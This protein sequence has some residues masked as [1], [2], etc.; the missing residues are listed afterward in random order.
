V[1][2]HRHCLESGDVFVLNGR[3]SK[4]GGLPLTL[5]RRGIRE[6][7]RITSLSAPII[8]TIKQKRNLIS[9]LMHS[10]CWYCHTSLLLYRARL[11]Y[12]VY[13]GI[14]VKFVVRRVGYIGIGNNRL[15]V[16]L[17]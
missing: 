7:P 10:D 5:G 13:G 2:K 9:R 11:W 14:L 3:A 6:L 15:F 16:D 12:I 17:G 4:R 8:Y 1:D